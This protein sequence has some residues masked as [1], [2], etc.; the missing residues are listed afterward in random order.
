MDQERQ[1]RFLIPPFFF[2]SSLLWGI[3]WSDPVHLN[4]HELIKGDLLL[5]IG[6]MAASALPLGYLIGTITVLSLKIFSLII[7]HNYEALFSLK[8]LLSMSET[9]Q[10]KIIEEDY[11]KLSR[12]QKMRIELNT[13]VV[14]DH[15]LHYNNSKGTHEWVMR[16][17][18]AVNISFNSIT[19]LLFAIISGYYLKYPASRS[20]PL[21]FRHLFS[22]CPV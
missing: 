21:W 5:Y 11:Q 18:N 12:F 6:I 3:Y 22:I 19:A 2:Y 9:I 4:W 15:E 14:F 16:R 20:K 10:K 7:G 8:T 17:W 1:I 13:A